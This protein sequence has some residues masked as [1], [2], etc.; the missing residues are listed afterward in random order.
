VPS[1]PPPTGATAPSVAPTVAASADLAVSVAQAGNFRTFTVTVVNN[2]PTTAESVRLEF[3]FLQ[4]PPS[5]PSG[6]SA[7]PD[8]RAIVCS[9][10]QVAA[11]RHPQVTITASGVADLVALSVSS[12]TPDPITANNGWRLA[13]GP[14]IVERTGGPLS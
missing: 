14:I 6:C 1:S 2:G 9:F 4:L 7:T 12:A 10:G 11:G 5:M 8:L 13:P 3:N